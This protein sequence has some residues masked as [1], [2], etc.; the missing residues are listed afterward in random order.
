MLKYG[1]F[2][3]AAPFVAAYRDTKKFW[4]QVE[5]VW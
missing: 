5:F 1:D 3:E 4:A 2:K